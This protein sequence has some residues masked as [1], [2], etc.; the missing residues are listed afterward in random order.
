MVTIN[1]K[2]NFPEVIAKMN[3][4][5]ADEIGSKALVSAMNKTLEQGRTAMTR[6]ITREFVIKAS[7]VRDQIRIDK[8]R[9]SKAGLKLVATLEAFGKRR[10]HR[11][12][13]VMLFG[14]RQVV[15]RKK[16]RVRFQIGGKWVTK[17]VP[18]GGGV[19]VRIKRNEGRKLI[20]GA[21]I[22]NKGRT[23]FTRR[24]G[25]GKQ[26]FA[27]ETIDIPQ[28]FNTRRINK[29]V[30]EFIETRFPVIFNNEARYFINRFNSKGV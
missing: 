16:K 15:G 20:K 2:T 6:A 18:V 17:D 13:N 25:R 21:F 29:Q 9:F 28:M 7:D 11:S 23:V 22:A 30:I 27:V 10:G 14:A 5:G 3:R 19:S 26:I 8:A 12:R 4:L 1:L 24:E